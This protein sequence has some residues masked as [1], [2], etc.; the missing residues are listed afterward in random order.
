MREDLRG[1]AP[2]P[3]RVRSLGSGLCFNVGRGIAA[4]A[5]FVLG[6]LAASHGLATSIGL[7]VPGFLLAGLVLLLLPDVP[8][9]DEVSRPPASVPRNESPA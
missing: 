8:A 9:A 2:Y 7:C 1:P 3:T 5:P 4:S 6:T